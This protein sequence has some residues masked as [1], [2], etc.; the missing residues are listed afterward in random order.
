[1]ATFK[2]THK[3]TETLCW[4]VANIR[5]VLWGTTYRAPTKIN[6]AIEQLCASVSLRQIFSLLVCIHSFSTIRAHT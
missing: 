1:M 5:F 6:F 2:I 3:N 4:Y